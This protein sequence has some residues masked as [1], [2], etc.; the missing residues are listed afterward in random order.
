MLKPT[1]IQPGEFLN[2]SVRELP[3]WAATEIVSHSGARVEPALQ[4]VGEH[5]VRQLGPAVGGQSSFVD[6]STVAECLLT[7]Q[8]RVVSA[9]ARLESTRAAHRLVDQLL[10]DNRDFDVFGLTGAH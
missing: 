1:L 6:T 8:H 10:R 3:G 5:E 2:S 7:R 4:F 9:P